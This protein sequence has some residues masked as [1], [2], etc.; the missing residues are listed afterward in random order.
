M[1]PLEETMTA[2]I[3][4]LRGVLQDLADP[5]A[6]MQRDLP[7]GHRLD[8]MMANAIVQN[9]HYYREAARKALE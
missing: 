6:A 3:K 4:R 7:E 5:I 1:N 2:E 9:P 8:G